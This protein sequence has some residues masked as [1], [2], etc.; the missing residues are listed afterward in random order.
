M[1]LFQKAT[2]WTG[3]LPAIPDQSRIVQK[4]L[5][6][7]WI[8]GQVLNGTKI[9][10]A[11]CVQMGQVYNGL[12]AHLPPFEEGKHILSAQFISGDFLGPH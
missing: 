12:F 4:L 5:K 11:D 8:M 7:V 10:C 1:P 6:F 2:R 9:L 3:H